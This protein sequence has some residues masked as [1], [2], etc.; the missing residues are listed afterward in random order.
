M[1]Q[2]WGAQSTLF[3]SGWEEPGNLGKTFRKEKM[4]KKEIFLI[5][6]EMPGEHK[7]AWSRGQ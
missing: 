6:Y 7:L 3:N 1:S 4:L 5:S 2:A